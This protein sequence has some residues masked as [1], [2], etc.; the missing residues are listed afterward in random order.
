MGEKIIDVTNKKSIEKILE[1]GIKRVQRITYRDIL[2]LL[3][4]ERHEY[5][6]TIIVC[7]NG[8]LYYSDKSTKKIISEMGKRYGMTYDQFVDKSKLDTANSMYKIPYIYKNIIAV[9]DSGT[10]R[11]NVNWFFLQHLIGYDNLKPIYNTRLIYDGIIIK[12]KISR[13]GFYRQLEFIYQ[14]Y[15]K[16]IKEIKDWGFTKA[17]EETFIYQN[18]LTFHEQEINVSELNNFY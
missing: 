2:A 14:Q 3:V 12:T 8:E 16:Q 7:C 1:K 13:E 9:P 6:Q 17:V 5:C 15:Y 4:V 18:T 10:A 11:G